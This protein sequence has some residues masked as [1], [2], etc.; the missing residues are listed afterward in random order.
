MEDL[1]MKN[2]TKACGKPQPR[3]DGDCDFCEENE[4]NTFLG[5]LKDKNG[6][7]N[8]Q[9][10]AED[11]VWAV[12]KLSKMLGLDEELDLPNK[13]FANFKDG[14]AFGKYLLSTIVSEVQVLQKSEKH[15]ESAENAMVEKDDDI[16][17]MKEKMLGMMSTIETCGKEILRHQRKESANAR[18]R[19][20]IAAALEDYIHE[21]E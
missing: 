9:F 1:I 8:I 20:K 21:V 14:V 13:K 6:K 12:K 11:M 3:C 15:L 5:Q 17:A 16:A 7:Y 19:E 2:S 10:D 18:L 4:D